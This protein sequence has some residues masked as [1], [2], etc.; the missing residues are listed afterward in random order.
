V[1][2]QKI[3][4]PYYARDAAA[5]ASSGQLGAD[6]AFVYFEVYSPRSTR[7]GRIVRKRTGLAFY[8]RDRRPIE[9]LGFLARF[10][11]SSGPSRYY[12]FVKSIFGLT[13][14]G[15]PRLT[16]GNQTSQ[17]SDRASCD[18]GFRGD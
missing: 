15:T 7:Y 17:L 14:T 10:E 18:H 1:G 3:G 8:L 13:G 5:P 11:Y 9:F 2:E 16:R 12:L 4:W 6:A